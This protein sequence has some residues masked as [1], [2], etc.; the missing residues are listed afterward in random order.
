MKK[1]PEI[2]ECVCYRNSPNWVLEGIIFG[3]YLCVCVE[4]GMRII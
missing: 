2:K 1:V 3:F 4:G